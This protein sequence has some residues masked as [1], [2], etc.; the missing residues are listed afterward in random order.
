[1]QSADR[2]QMRD[3]I[4]LVQL[5]GVFFQTAFISQY[6]RLED[7]QILL[8]ADSLQDIRRPTLQT[9]NPLEIRRH[10]ASGLS[11]YLSIH[12]PAIALGMIIRGIIKLSWISRMSEPLQLPDHTD[13]LAN[14]VFLHNRRL[15]LCFLCHLLCLHI[16]HQLR[17]RLF[18]LQI[19]PPILL[20]RLDRYNFP[21]YLSFFSFTG[22][23][24]FLPHFHLPLLLP[25]T[26]HSKKHKKERHHPH[27]QI[28][29]ALIPLHPQNHSPAAQKHQGQ[30]LPD[31]RQ[32]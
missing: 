29:A 28:S 18:S 23:H 22:F 19:Q 5:S 6:Y 20:S 12:L 24:K 4:S 13:P 3:P 2:Q 25:Q 27:N 30:D 17:I 1:M 26:H 10:T 31:H 9:V 11:H 14:P 16:N 15:A 8:L 32:P 7:P 21:I